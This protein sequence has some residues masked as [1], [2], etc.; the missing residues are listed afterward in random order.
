MSGTVQLAT[1]KRRLALVWFAG[2]TPLFL[3]VLALSLTSPGIG[4]PAWAWFLPTVMPNLSLI[5]GVYV[6]DARAG[7]QA[8]RP[9]DRFTFMMTAYL[10]G[11]YLL[12][13]ATLFL[14]HPFYAQGLQAWLTA[15]QPWLAA[16]QGLTALAMGAFYVQP[17]VAP[18]SGT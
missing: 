15:S 13:I 8:D 12:C 2:A 6:A 9:V 16:L 3:F 18:E 4:A 11:F 10:S 1:A 14:T 17:A 5:V 7:Q